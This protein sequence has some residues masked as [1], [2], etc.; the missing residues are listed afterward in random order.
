MACY[1][2]SLS[3]GQ[4]GAQAGHQSGR[5]DTLGSRQQAELGS[6]VLHPAGAGECS[7]RQSV[8]VCLHLENTSISI[9]IKLCP[10]F[11]HWEFDF[12][13]KHRET[14]FFT[15]LWTCFQHDMW[16]LLK[17]FSVTVNLTLTSK[18][19]NEPRNWEWVQFG[20]WPCGKMKAT[21]R[22]SSFILFI[23]LDRFWDLVT[24]A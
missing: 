1:S 9:L 2:L 18:I 7:H 6:D 4:C 11:D 8:R 3:W 17:G 14:C 19:V 16:F 20:L 23:I 21:I 12:Y 15:S 13:M 5:P 22:S 10:E 24:P